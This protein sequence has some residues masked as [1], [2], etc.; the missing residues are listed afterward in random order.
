MVKESGKQE[1][2]SCSH[3]VGSQG[4]E[5]NDHWAQISFLFFIQLRTSVH[6]VMQL[7]FR[8]G[9]LYSIIPFWQLFATHTQKCV[10]MVI[11]NPTKLTR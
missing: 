5:S 9:H 7:T 8:V 2:D 4:A 6:G 10:A 3:R 11:L 1:Q